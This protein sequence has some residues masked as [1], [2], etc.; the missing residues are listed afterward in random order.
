M[1]TKLELQTAPDSAIGTIGILISQ[2]EEVARK[3]DELVAPRANELILWRLTYN[4]H[5]QTPEE[6]ETQECSPVPVLFGGVSLVD[7]NTFWEHGRCDHIIQFG[8]REV[9]LN[10]RTGKILEVEEPP[11]ITRIALS[12]RS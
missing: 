1:R 10:S 4:R 8:C 2:W 9:S 6:F 7:A 5:Q 12:L 11:I 3:V